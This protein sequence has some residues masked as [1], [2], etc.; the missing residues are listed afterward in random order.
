MNKQLNA[1]FETA[2]ATKVPHP[3]VWVAPTSKRSKRLGP[4]R[5]GLKILL[6]ALLGGVAAGSVWFVSMARKPAPR[7]DS[8][9]PAGQTEPAAVVGLGYLEPSTTVVKLGAPGNP[10]SSRISSLLVSEGQWVEAGQSLATM[11]SVDRLKAQV[12]QSEAQVELKKLML[13]R[14]RR[15]IANTTQ[16]RRSALDRARADIDQSQAEYDRQKTLVDRSFATLSNLEKKAKD[17]QTAQATRIEMEAALE[18]IE[19]KV[20]GTDKSL[21]IALTEQELLCAQADLAVTKAS[22]E[23][24]IIRAPFSGRVLSL[25]ARAGERVGNDGVLEF[26]ATDEMRAVIE[27]YQTDVDRI[28]VGQSV[29]IRAD[30]ISTSLQGRVDHIGDAIA[31]Q[32]VVNNDPASS[33]DARVVQ[34]YVALSK[35]D[36]E[37]V[38]KLSRLQVR[39]VFAK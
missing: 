24:G 39:G 35:Q 17:L 18:R 10:D 12:A 27:V 5:L 29:E 30:A 1:E 33:T 7:T 19:A 20:P 16:A 21:D 8:A 23:L 28:R 3:D 15:E 13:E 2:P 36:S 9:V 14:Q 4:K 34:I 6:I 26:G 37:R 31:R 11:D 25:K 22:L 32:T 38:A